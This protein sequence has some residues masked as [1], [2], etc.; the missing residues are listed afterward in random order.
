MVLRLKKLKFI[1]T[2]LLRKAWL[3]DIPENTRKRRVI[4]TWARSSSVPSLL[5]ISLV[6]VHKGN[7]FNRV[8][9][10]KLIFFKKFGELAFSRKP[11]YYPSIKKKKK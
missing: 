4:K 6:L 3:R 10:T 9:Y 7:S 5:G 1:D 11:F 2:G 8:Q